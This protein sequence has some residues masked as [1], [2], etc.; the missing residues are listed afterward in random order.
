MAKTKHIIARG[1]ILWTIWSCNIPNIRQMALSKHFNFTYYF[2]FISIFVCDFLK[3]SNSKFIF[4]FKQLVI[5]KNN[6]MLLR[7]IFSQ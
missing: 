2:V 7:S 5:W 6:E 1:A 3:W 4:H